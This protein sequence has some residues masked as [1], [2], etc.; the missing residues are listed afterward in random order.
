[1][2]SPSKVLVLGSASTGTAIAWP[3]FHA[4]TAWQA[5]DVGLHAMSGVLAD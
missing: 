3:P 2:S 5:M 1:M 4:G